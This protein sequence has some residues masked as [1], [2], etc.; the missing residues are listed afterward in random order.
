MSLLRGATLSLVLTFLF[1]LFIGLPYRLYPAE[2]QKYLSSPYEWM[3]Q[4]YFTFYLE[5]WRALNWLL[6]QP[7]GNMLLLAMA[8]AN[9]LSAALTF[10]ITVRLTK[11]YWCGAIA[12][13]LFT[14]SAW[15]TNY[16]WMA[17]Y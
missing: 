1:Q 13:F 12:A 10:L 5:N 2:D 3:H 9:G 6:V 14:V 7:K 16:L 15:T 17:S 8:F 4:P 11:N